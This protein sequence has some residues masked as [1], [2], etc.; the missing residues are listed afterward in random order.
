[1]TVDEPIAYVVAHL[2]EAILKDERF[3]EQAVEIEAIEGRII[4]RG[5]V[6]TPERRSGIVDLVRELVPDCTVVD[7]LCVSA[8]TPPIHNAETL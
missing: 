1:V 2:H 7:D 5:E 3:T 6:A 8:T 4:L